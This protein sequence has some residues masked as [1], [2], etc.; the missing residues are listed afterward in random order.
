M[1]AR[2]A[3]AGLAVACALAAGVLSACASDQTGAPAAARVTHAAST[4]S[5][6]TASAPPDTAEDSST[7]D[8]GGLSVPAETAGDLDA[9]DVPAPPDLGPGWTQYVD[10]GEAEDGYVGNGSWV[11]ARGAEEVVQ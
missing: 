11:R 8:G 9:S 2:R 4:A 3:S 1:T 5:T 10:P 7:S 6:Q